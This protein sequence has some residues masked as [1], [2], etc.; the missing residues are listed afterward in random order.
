MNHG[1]RGHSDIQIWKPVE[2]EFALKIIRSLKSQIVL[3]QETFLPR[4]FFSVLKWARRHTK[5]YNVRL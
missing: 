4:P 1:V 2:R 3:L 5:T